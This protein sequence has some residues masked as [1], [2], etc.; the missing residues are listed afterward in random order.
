M[1]FTLELFLFALFCSVLNLILELE[2]IGF[3][4]RAFYRLARRIQLD[5]LLRRICNYYLSGQTF[6]FF[7]Y[8]VDYWF[9]F[10]FFV[11][12][13]DSCSRYSTSSTWSALLTFTTLRLT[14]RLTTRNTW[15]RLVSFIIKH[16]NILRLSLNFIRLLSIMKSLNY[17][18]LIPL[19]LWFRS[20]YH[21]S[22]LLLIRNKRINYLRIIIIILLRVAILRTWFSLFLIGSFWLFFWYIEGIII[23]HTFGV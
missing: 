7:R 22:L 21:S 8:R 18:L 19:T 20:T 4:V 2:C 5:K 13:F 17:N 14:T 11:E 12:K 6:N 16:K 9:N 10:L 15:L 1:S 3:L 23:F